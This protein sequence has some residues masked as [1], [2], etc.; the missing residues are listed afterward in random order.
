MKTITKSFLPE[1]LLNPISRNLIFIFVL[2][3][4]IAVTLV[5][6]VFLLLN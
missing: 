5:T 3:F 1:I 6:A 2:A 4:V